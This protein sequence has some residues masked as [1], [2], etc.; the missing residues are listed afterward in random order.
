MHP[1]LIVS[2]LPQLAIIIYSLETTRE[3]N[4]GL[5]FQKV[6]GCRPVARTKFWYYQP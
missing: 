1:K 4:E 5:R 6:K 2:A 3:A